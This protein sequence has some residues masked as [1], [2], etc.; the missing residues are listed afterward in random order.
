MLPALC[1][2]ALR[3]PARPDELAMLLSYA[4]V[5]LLLANPL[6]IRTALLSGILAGLTFC[7]STGVLLGFLPLIAA[8]WLL[9]V[10]RL[11]WLSL[12]AVSAAG[13]LIADAICL[14]PLYLI[15][16]AFYHQFLQHANAQVVKMSAWERISGALQLTWLVARIGPLP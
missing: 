14:V 15:E 9:R 6:R 12:L 8:C 4:N 3:Q 13:A 5:W 2:L 7:T 16:P 11:R 10:D 1:T